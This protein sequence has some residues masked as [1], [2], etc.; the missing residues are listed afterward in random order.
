[1]RDRGWRAEEAH[2]DRRWRPGQQARVATRGPRRKNE[3]ERI[4][5]KK[6]EKKEKEKNLMD[7]GPICQWLILLLMSLKQTENG[8]VPSFLNQT[9]NEL[10][11]SHN[12]EIGPSH[13][14][15]S[16]NQTLPKYSREDTKLHGSVGHTP[17]ENPKI[18][19]FSS[20]S[21][22]RE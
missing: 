21:Q 1:M 22:M 3:E 12:T 2:G 7:V 17:R 14:T 15:L 11:P 20:G 8:L 4:R 18:H 13:P 10:I 19:I 5:K 9:E 16:P 6:K